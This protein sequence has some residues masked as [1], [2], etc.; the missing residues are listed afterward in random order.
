MLTEQ[1]TTHSEIYK[2]D[3][4]VE[5]ADGNTLWNIWYLTSYKLLGISLV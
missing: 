1:T 2:I 4:N 5:R 3:Q